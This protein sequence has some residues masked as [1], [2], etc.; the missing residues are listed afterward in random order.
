MVEDYG[1]CKEIT[2]TTEYDTIIGGGKN[3]VDEVYQ[4]VLVLERCLG[5]ID[6]RVLHFLPHHGKSLFR[7]GYYKE[8][9]DIWHRCAVIC[10]KVLYIVDEYPDRV[11]ANK[12]LVSVVKVVTRLCLAFH[13]AFCVKIKIDFEFE[14]YIDFFISTQIVLQKQEHQMKDKPHV[15]VLRT[16]K[17]FMWWFDSLQ[18][19]EGGSSSRYR[20]SESFKQ[21]CGNFVTS[22][23]YLPKGSS[24]LHSFLKYPCRLAGQASLKTEFL[25]TLL[26]LGASDAI[27]F[28]ASSKGMRPLH[29]CSNDASFTKTLL[30]Y[31]PHIDAV[32]ASGET[33]LSCSSKD[34]PVYPL[35]L[36]TGPLL[37]SC[38]ASQSVVA[39]N[40][41][42]HLIDLPKH[43]V[44]LIE[45]HDPQQ[46][47][48]N[49]YF[50]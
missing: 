1:Y 36:A 32:N 28:P 15:L 12:L 38:F 5:L 39:A 29:L 31:G 9:F 10:K 30:A 17:M 40:I 14:F 47:R 41:P 34:G 25:D 26:L 19:V 13:R 37:L 44:K 18:S 8:A 16:L 49:D 11:D 43:I 23:L 20:V 46:I 48:L 21:H 50:S 33:A 42:Y 24:I 35:L 27:N 7:L 6:T 2:T 3:P 22:F 45:L 4:K